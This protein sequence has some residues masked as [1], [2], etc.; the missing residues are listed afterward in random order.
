MQ[1]LA[2]MRGDPPHANLE[3]AQ[4][5]Y[6]TKPQAGYI[7]GLGGNGLKDAHAA[8]AHTLEWSSPGI[9]CVARAT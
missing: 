8:D 1:Q 7:V 9:N 6:N 2:W 3:N 5:G 4:F